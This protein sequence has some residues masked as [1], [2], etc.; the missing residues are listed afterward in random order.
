MM[1]RMGMGGEDEDAGMELFEWVKSNVGGGAYVLG[2]FNEVI[3][4]ERKIENK[5]IVY[6][7]ILLS[8]GGDRKGSVE[9]LKEWEQEEIRAGEEGRAVEVRRKWVNLV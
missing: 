1:L 4:S 2:F 6:G 5:R 9:V 8:L 3:G 7:H